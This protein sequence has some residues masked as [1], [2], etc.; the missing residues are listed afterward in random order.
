ML[1][2]LETLRQVGALEDLDLHF[3]RLIARVGDGEGPVALAAALASQC[4][5]QGHICLDL[6]SVAGT[7]VGEEVGEGAIEAPPLDQ[8]VEQLRR[9]PAVGHPGTFAPLVLDEAGRLYLYRYWDY[10]REVAEALALRIQDDPADVDV[11]GLRAGLDRLFPVPA[12]GPDWQR[13]AAAAAV[14]RRLTVISGGPGTGKTTTVIRLLALLLEQGGGRPLRIGLAAPT[15]K[16][17]ARMQDV[18]R[19]AKRDLPVEAS[20][21]DAIPEKASTIHRLLG[22]R[23]GTVGFRH[24]R[25]NPLGLDVLVVDEASMVDLALMAKLIRALP[26]AARLILVGDRDQLASVEA[27]AV[28]GDIC[29]ESPG[30]SSAFRR[31]LHEATGMDPGGEACPERFDR[32][33]LGLVE[34][35]RPELVEGGDG[36]PI[37]DAV[38]LLQRSYRFGEQSGIGQV[39]RLVNQ[40]K[41]RQAFELLA[42]GDFPDIA[43]RAVETPGELRRALAETAADAFRDA[44]SAEDPES[45]L[46]ALDGFRILCARRSGPFGLEAVN[47]LVEDRLEATHLISLRGIWYWGRPILVTTNDYHLRLFNGDLG[48]ALP[49]PEADQSLR[50]F[51]R[52]AEGGLRRI[53][54]ARL[55]IHET[56]YATTVHKS[57]GSEAE[58][59]LLILPNE[60]SPVMTRELIYTGLTRARSRVEVWG[61]RAVF[62]AAVSRRLTRSSGLRDALWRSL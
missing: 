58:R 47:G 14:L 40:G 28:L 44:V 26:P 36:P 33:Q 8:W 48:V 7:R 6:A 9:C 29:G 62:E 57:Q 37:R 53:P 34:G 39:A 54:P 15:G 43:W 52:A 1:D 22:W 49:D 31:R 27:G 16:A 17:A 23:P 25:E 38:M 5:G 45:A 10:Q 61:T 32:A 55:P 12:G 46:A 4:T 13:I 51:F 59:V 42:G 50:V 56:A 19:A 35:S 11:P 60:A 21:R 41:G 18:I 24:D 2:R 20:V 30:V 3:A